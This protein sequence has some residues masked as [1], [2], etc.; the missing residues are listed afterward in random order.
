MSSTNMCHTHTFFENNFINKIIDRKVKVTIT[1]II[2]IHQLHVC[3]CFSKRSLSVF[4]F[5]KF[6]SVILTLS[7]NF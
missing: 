3:V 1:N 7:S 5:E 6:V 2:H 4:N